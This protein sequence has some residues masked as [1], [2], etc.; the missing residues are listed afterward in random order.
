MS[1]HQKD[2]LDVLE[3]VSPA[4]ADRRETDGRP[5]WFVRVWARLFASR[6]DEEI[7]A[8]VAPVD[9]SPLATHWMR[10]TSVRERHDLAFTLCR[11]VQDAQGTRS[12]NCSRIPVH[13]AAVYRAS[14]V[15]DEVLERLTGPAPVRARGMAR[16]RILLADGRGPLFRAGPGTLTAAMR[17]ALAAL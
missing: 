3:S 11:V 6:F 12:R 8:G 2:W 10:L 4:H 1:S 13:A 9:G 5:P 15:I 7:E 14:D 16:L 17:G